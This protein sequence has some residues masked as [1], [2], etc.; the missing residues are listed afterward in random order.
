MEVNPNS[1]QSNGSS[2]APNALGNVQRPGEYLRQ[3]RITQKLELE[4]VASELNI[5]LKTLTALEQDDYKSLPEATFI[6][7]YYRTYAKYLKVDA[8]NIIQRFDDIYANDTG[9]LPNHALNNSPIKIMGK[10]PGSNRDR[11]RKWIKRG[12]IALAVLVVIGAIVAAIQGMT[13]GSDNEDAVTSDVASEVQVLDMNGGNAAVSGDQLTLTFSSP[14][15]VHIVDS[16]GKV[17]ATGRQAST[18]NLSGET[19]FQ[20]RLDDA[21]AVSLSLNNENISLSPYTVNGKADF[22]LSR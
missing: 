14:T 5:P 16:T 8:T 19:P 3:V 6:K 15:S 9:L 13:S 2:V 17:L 12:L 18:L 4:A 11:N 21:T 22:R 7:G 1:P 20:I 10:L